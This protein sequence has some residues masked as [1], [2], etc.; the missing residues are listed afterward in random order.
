MQST[1]VSV[2]L[3]SK[4]INKKEILEVNPFTALQRASRTQNQFSS[5]RFESSESPGKQ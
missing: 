4:R 3:G 5:S 1:A 2:F